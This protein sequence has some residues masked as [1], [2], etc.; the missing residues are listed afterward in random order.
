MHSAAVIRSTFIVLLVCL[1]FFAIAKWKLTWSDEFNGKTIDKKKWDVLDSFRGN[2]PGEVQ[3]YMAHNV[4]VKKGK[5]I[6][7]AR[8]ENANVKYYGKPYTVAYTSGRVESRFKF[9]QKYGRFAVKAK[10]P[11]GRGLWPAI[12]LMP[13]NDKKY[14]WPHGG[15]IDIMENIG[16]DMHASYTTYHYGTKC[17]N[18]DG[19]VDSVHHGRATKW[20]N[21][22]F[23]L[24]KGYH[25]YSVEWDK[26]SIKWYVDKK[27]VFTMQNN[28]KAPENGVVLKIPKHPFGFILNLAI[29]GPESGTFPG[30]LASS[31]KLP[32]KFVI[33]YARIYKKTK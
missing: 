20:I 30:P 10:L 8:R 3:G 19:F 5:L 29:G 4:K 6:L 17:N 33:D 13:N 22:G 2:P 32:T 15:E 11:R 18:Q 16:N 21:N 28:F 27:C 1:P 14:C 12:W 23:D 26:K 25:E 31:T 24:S 9:S 7:S